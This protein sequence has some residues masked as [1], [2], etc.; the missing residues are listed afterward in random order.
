MAP[1]QPRRTTKNTRKHRR[2][3]VRMLVDYQ[4]KGGIHCD[5]ATTLGAG[6]MFLQTELSMSRG[7]IVKVRFRIPGGEELHELEARVTWSHDARTEPDG[8]VRMPGVGLQFTDPTLTAP[9]A[10]ELEDYEG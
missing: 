7:D 1:P 9:L 2:M 8:S 5:Y 4:A 3:T 6:G 10:R